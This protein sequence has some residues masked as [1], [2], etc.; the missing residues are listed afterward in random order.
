MR[1]APILAV[2]LLASLATAVGAQ[3]E[4]GFDPPPG[5]RGGGPPP[6]RLEALGLS[7]MQRAKIDSLR[8]EEARRTIRLRADVR[9]AE[10]DLDRLV[11]GDGPAPAGAEVDRLVRRVT[12]LRGEM[13]AARVATQLGVR[14]ILTAAQRAKLRDMRPQGRRPPGGPP[15]PGGEPR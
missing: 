2:L 7:P 3:T 13:L 15:P 11:G 4:P 5:M 8:D 6:P 12:D 14:G 1:R 9:I 10:L